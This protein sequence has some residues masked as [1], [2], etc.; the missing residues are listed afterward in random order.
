MQ[1][2][3][4]RG[5]EATSIKD[6]AEHTG[7]AVASLYN[8]FGDK[9]G[10]FHRAFDD[11]VENGIGERI[12]RLRRQ[13]P[14]QAIEAFFREIVSRSL[15][16]DQRKGCMLVNSA[17]ELAPHDVEFHQRIALALDRIEAFFLGCLR[18]GQRDGSIARAIPPR[19]LARH[20]MAVLLGVRVLARVRPDRATLEGAVGPALAWLEPLPLPGRAGLPR[21]RR[22]GA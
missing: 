8:A 1:C 15:D 2:F 7:I 20:L 5:Y 22:R 9:R 10:L 17:L 6:L 14:R 13:P 19:T 4:S 16:D 21:P 18:R 3:W 11:Y 12:S